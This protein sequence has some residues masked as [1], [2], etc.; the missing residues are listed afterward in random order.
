[1]DDSIVSLKNDGNIN[2]TDEESTTEKKQYVFAL[3]FFTTDYNLV[4]FLK[5]LYYTLLELDKDNCILPVDPSSSQPLDR[6][7]PP[8][9]TIRPE[10]SGKF[11]AGLYSDRSGMRGK[12]S[13]QIST[14]PDAFKKNQT[15]A[16]WYRGDDQRARIQVQIA[17][18]SSSRRYKAGTLHH[19]VCRPDMTGIVKLHLTR[20]LQA[21]TKRKIVPFEV[22]SDLVF[23]G[24]NKM[25]QLYHVYAETF[26]DAQWL[27]AILDAITSKKEYG[28][29]F[30]SNQNWRN[31]SN[32]QKQSYI[33]KQIDFSNKTDA[34]ILTGITNIEAPAVFGSSSSATPTSL[35]HH[36]ATTNVDGNHLFLHVTP[37]Y[38]GKTA[39]WYQRKHKQAVSIWLQ[40]AHIDLFDLVSN[41]F[42]ADLP[43]ERRM[44]ILANLFVDSENLNRQ[45][46]HVASLKEDDTYVRPNESHQRHTTRIHQSKHKNGIT[47]IINNNKR[48]TRKSYAVVLTEAKEPGQGNDKNNKRGKRKKKKPVT[49]YEYENIPGGIGCD[50][51]PKEIEVIKSKQSNTPQKT[52]NPME[53]VWPAINLATGTTN[54]DLDELA[55]IVDDDQTEVLDEAKREWKEVKHSRKSKMQATPKT[56]ATAHRSEIP[57]TQMKSPPGMVV[58][59]T[60]QRSDSADSSLATRRS[61]NSPG[62]NKTRLQEEVE[63][64]QQRERE[65]IQRQDE[66]ERKHVEAINT[67][68]QQMQHMMQLLTQLVGPGQLQAAAT[69]PTQTT[70][71]NYE[72]P[73]R[74]H[75]A[76]RQPAEY[77]VSD[78]S[79]DDTASLESDPKKQRA[80]NT[81][82]K[83]MVSGVTAHPLALNSPSPQME[84]DEPHRN[85]DSVDTVL[86]QSV[87][88]RSP[89]SNGP[90]EEAGDN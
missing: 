11:V 57:G 81:P 33:E 70:L 30:V 61:E 62:S 6:G 26:D 67:L 51:A 65:L 55:T 2:K 41:S 49:E 28:S 90:G 43:S 72:T 7:H 15:V 69:T 76:K 88:S 13:V 1:M 87:A 78:Q 50:D 71:V 25:A 54:D 20:L 19:Y 56:T 35:A 21:R 73:E 44:E 9:R 3:W 53:P 31:F 16:K 39:L 47:N 60:R 29:F 77:S 10:D 4:S 8:P 58:R 84:L 45:R 38:E 34:V 68:N 12:I 59:T 24:K 75:T 17:Q 42:P 83:H 27:G 40:T 74:S 36:I 63:Y 48:P 82:I 64:L 37:T 23:R 5:G 86:R 89:P 22:Q 32:S 85:L 80:G 79:L 52:S 18:I 66:M 14:H 46:Q